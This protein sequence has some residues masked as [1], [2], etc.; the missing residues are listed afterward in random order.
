MYFRA[1]SNNKPVHSDLWYSV[2][3]TDPRKVKIEHETTDTGK[4]LEERELRPSDEMLIK[5]FVVEAFQW[6][7]RALE[8]LKSQPW[9]SNVPPLKLESDKPTEQI[10][11]MMGA[12]ILHDRDEW[13]TFMT[14]LNVSMVFGLKMNPLG[15]AALHWI[16]TT[17]EGRNEYE[18]VLLTALKGDPAFPIKFPEWGMEDLLCQMITDEEIALQF[19]RY[20]LGRNAEF[21]TI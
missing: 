17:D 19:L 9:A 20:V 10:P 12:T 11:A 2:N 4:N 15:E 18:R 8:E 21:S 6:G 3:L 7:R 5:H 16:Q 1:S 13:E 14:S